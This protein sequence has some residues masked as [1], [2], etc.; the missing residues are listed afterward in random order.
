MKSLVFASSLLLV[1]TALAEGCSGAV[2]V[3]SDTSS[4]HDTSNTSDGGNCKPL[5]CPSNA[6]WD[7]A[8]CA[9]VAP[10][11]A[12]TGGEAG[13]GGSCTWPASAD[14]YDDASAVGCRPSSSST[15]KICQEAPDGAQTCQPE[16]PANDYVLG[17]DGNAQAPSSLDCMIVPIPTPEGVSIYCCP[18]ATEAGT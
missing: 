9:C 11:D 8:K 12:S 7:A 10:E 17:C 5:P 3:G 16:C 4:D 2:S 6:S 1:A 14:T 18:C 13:S 15:A